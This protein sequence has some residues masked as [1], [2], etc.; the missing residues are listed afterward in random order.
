V[1]L[2]FAGIFYSRAG[3]SMKL[4]VLALAVS[5]SMGTVSVWWNTAVEAY[6]N[7]ASYYPATYTIRIEEYN[8]D[9]KLESAEWGTMIQRW[10][11][12]SMETTVLRAEK[13]G[14][15]VTKEWQK[16]FD[17]QSSASN[18]SGG[19]PEGF[20]ISPFEK[21]YF[22]NLV[23]DTGNIAVIEGQVAVP[24]SVKTKKAA[25][26][27]VVYFNTDGIPLNAVQTYSTL[28]PLVKSLTAQFTYLQV[29]S[30]IVMKSFIMDTVVNAVVAVKRYKVSMVFD[31]W[32][33]K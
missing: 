17:K 28:P 32:K 25:A 14:K 23:I 8:R 16:R 12:S 33:K 4:S 20:D 26:Q 10:T 22:N 9:N 7:A 21:K 6:T 30:A 15:D 24:Y 2:D 11:G 13:N 1:F 3:V 31:Q 5:L 27:G 29:E 18:S 19:P